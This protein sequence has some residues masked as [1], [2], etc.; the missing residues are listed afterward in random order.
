MFTSTEVARRLNLHPATL[1][2]WLARGRIRFERVGHFR[3]V[4]DDELR[5]LLRE[6]NRRSSHGAKGEA[7]E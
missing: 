1:R 3:A 7:A 5:R 2:R 4:P 6:R